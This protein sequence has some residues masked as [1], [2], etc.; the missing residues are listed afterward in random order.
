MIADALLIAGAA[1]AAMYCRVLANRLNALKNLDTGLGAAIAALSRQVDEMRISL[2]TAKSASGDQT[3]ALTQLTARGEMAA[4]RLELLLAALHE[5]GRRKPISVSE[6][7][8][9]RRVASVS[10]GWAEEPFATPPASEAAEPGEGEVPPKPVS[11]GAA[12][13]EAADVLPMEEVETPGD[14]GAKPSAQVLTL[15]KAVEA[16]APAADA[17]PESP[18]AEL[19][20]TLVLRWSA[21]P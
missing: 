5:N 9:G 7:S 8:V 2:E 18:D 20:R 14:A 15:S 6:P 3:R 21:A 17:S 12:G 11:E 16:A 19:D 10:K 13:A 1:G 4:G